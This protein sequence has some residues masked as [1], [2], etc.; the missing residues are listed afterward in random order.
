MTGVFTTY[1]DWGYSEDPTG[2]YRA[3]LQRVAQLD[4][5]LALPGHGRPTPELDA[6]LMLYQD[7]FA[8]RLEAVRA[9]TAP[10]IWDKA[11]DVFGEPPFPYVAVWNFYE[12]AGYLRHLALR[13]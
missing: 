13:R 9:S 7:G 12:T 2:D 5:A 11:F 6:L 3:S 10:T 4:V 1:G 8:E